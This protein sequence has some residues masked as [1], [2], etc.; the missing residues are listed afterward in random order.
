MQKMEIIFLDYGG[1][2]YET[3]EM[4]MMKVDLITDLN[5]YENADWLKSLKI[6]YIKMSIEITIMRLLFM[7]H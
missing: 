1:K 2:I 5:G 3:H 4:F 6:K 7:V